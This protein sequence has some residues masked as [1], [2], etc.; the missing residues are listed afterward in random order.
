MGLYVL[1]HG[2]RFFRRRP[3]VPSGRLGRRSF[4]KRAALASIV[5][6]SIGGTH[7]AALALSISEAGQGVAQISGR[8]EFGDDAT[9]ETFLGQSRAQPIRLLKLDSPGGRVSVAA[10]IAQTIRKSRISTVV[11]AS[12]ARCESA[13]TLIFAGGVKRYY[14]NAESI[15]DGV[16]FGR[17]IAF[18]RGNDLSAAR[19]E[20]PRV[21]QRMLDTFRTMGMPAAAKFVAAAG[22]V[23]L[24]RVSGPT[25]LKARV[26]TSLTP[27]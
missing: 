2:L 11:D 20:D 24:Y 8:I 23:D 3:K 15:L 1:K 6:L 12:S 9:V 22:T 13:C 27:P 19:D 14:L 7:R 10:R 17:G 25:A 21:T 26:A 4:V 16:G 18:H 5:A